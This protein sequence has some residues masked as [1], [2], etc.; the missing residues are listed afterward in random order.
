MGSSSGEEVG[1][2]VWPD[3]RMLI[4]VAS[5]C[6][7]R[8]SG[9]ILRARAEVSIRILVTA[10]K[11]K[12]S[13]GRPSLEIK[14]PPD[15]RLGASTYTARELSSGKFRE[16]SARG[17]APARAIGLTETHFISGLRSLRQ[18]S[19]TSSSQPPAAGAYDGRLGDDKTMK[20]ATRCSRPT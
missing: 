10:T 7:A 4:D 12:S 1:T 17:Q 2:G 19:P 6:W 5:F 16:R 9:V 14:P 3:V 8:C 11:D 13:A 20:Q 18:T 15:W